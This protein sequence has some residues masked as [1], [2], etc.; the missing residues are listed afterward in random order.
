M[1]DNKQNMRDNK[2][3][4]KTEKERNKVKTLQVTE[5]HTVFI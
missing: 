5:V 1:R 3:N 2:Q 4:I